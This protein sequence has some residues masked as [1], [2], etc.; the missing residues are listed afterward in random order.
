LGAFSALLVVTGE[1]FLKLDLDIL[2]EAKSSNVP[3]FFVRNKAD[4]G[5]DGIL[6]SDPE[7]SWAEAAKELKEKVEANFREQMEKAD[8]WPQPLYVISARKLRSFVRVLA[9]KYQPEKL[10]LIDEARLVD[11]ISCAM[12]SW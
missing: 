11:D 9:G 3:V 5:I 7:M 8:L 12:H 2:I 10:E 1:R 6:D 4:Q